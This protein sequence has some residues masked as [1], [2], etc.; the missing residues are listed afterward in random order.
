IDDQIQA[1]GATSVAAE[2]GEG[3]PV[4]AASAP[5]QLVVHAEK[6]E[7]GSV[8]GTLTNGSGTAQSE[9]VIYAVAKRGSRVVA[10]GRAVLA[11]V[12][13]GASVPF[14]VFFVGNPQGAQLQLSAPTTTSAG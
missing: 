9:L 3:K 12:A 11:S 4:G 6:P 2:V 5:A 8:E 7:E 10:A 14:Q 13:A 1:S